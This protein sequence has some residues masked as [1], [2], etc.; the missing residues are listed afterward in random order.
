VYAVR[1]HAISDIEANKAA[2]EQR[3]ALRTVPT[4]VTNQMAAG[5]R[6]RRCLTLVMCFSTLRCL[7]LPMA[8]LVC[9]NPCTVSAHPLPQQQ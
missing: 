5:P 6:K 8:C 1:E 9:P 7:E 3:A 2:E 4:F